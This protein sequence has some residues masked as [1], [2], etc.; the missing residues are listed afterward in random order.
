MAQYGDLSIAHL[1]DYN[2]T[3][4]DIQKIKMAMTGTVL[5]FGVLFLLGKSSLM[6]NPLT[7][8]MYIDSYISK[9]RSDKSIDTAAFWEFRDFYSSR[10]STF[11]SDAIQK[12]E[13]F[14][15]F[16]TPAIQSKDYLL[17]GKL[18]SPNMRVIPSGAEVVMQTDRELVYV[19]EKKLVMRFTKTIEEMKKVNGFFS[20]FGIDLE[21]YKDHQWYNE[22]SVT[23]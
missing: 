23:N 17:P 8:K 10:S 2:I 9:L 20:Y 12:G 13:P 19:Y 7:R 11:S 6:L 15:T 21:K 4:M 18:V 16:D 3:A 5:V 22:T 14:L 1:V